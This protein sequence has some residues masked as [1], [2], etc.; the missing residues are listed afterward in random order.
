MRTPSLMWNMALRG[1][2]W[3]FP[4]GLLLGGIY[5]I[6]VLGIV[7]LSPRLTGLGS[8]QPPPALFLIYTILLLGLIGS[9]VGGLIGLA[10]GPLGGLFCFALTRLFFFPLQN[11]RRYRFVVEIAGALYGMATTL[12]CTQLIGRLPI[13]PP[14]EGTGNLLLFHLFPAIIAGAVCL[15]IGR[16]IAAWYENANP[17]N[18]AQD[19]PGPVTSA[20]PV[21]S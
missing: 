7:A 11:G 18:R 4:I 21:A 10:A 9:L 8:S 15:Y 17:G 1:G 6:V 13:A 2:V 19:P 16:Q 5:S 3:G 20:R 12:I 14:I